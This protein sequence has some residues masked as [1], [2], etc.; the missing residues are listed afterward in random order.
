MEINLEILKKKYE[1]F[2]WE[3]ILKLCKKNN[4]TTKTWQKISNIKINSNNLIDIVKYYFDNDMEDNFI[5]FLKKFIENDIVYLKNKLSNKN[6]Y[7]DYLIILWNNHSVDDQINLNLLKEY[8]FI[9]DSDKNKTITFP[10]Y[11]LVILP[12]IVKFNK[13]ILPKIEPKDKLLKITNL[14]KNNRI[15]FLEL[16]V[17]KLTEEITSLNKKFLI[18]KNKTEKSFK[19]MEKRMLDIINTLNKQ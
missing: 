8:P 14:K 3:G 19:I 11:L 5:K 17:D 16:Q 6:Y 18:H 15:E 1:N 13:Y 10:N 4:F 2:N 9:F 7:S 12:R